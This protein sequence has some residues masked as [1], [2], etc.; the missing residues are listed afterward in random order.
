MN[1]IL[2]L[3][4]NKKFVTSFSIIFFLFSLTAIGL[5]I[6]R[7]FIDENPFER[8]L[9][10]IFYFT[11]QSNL[12][13][14]IILLLFIFKKNNKKW[15]SVLCFI[16]LI[17]ITITGL[18]FHLFLASY[19]TSIGL[20][21]HLLHTVIPILYLFFYFFIFSH[22]LQ[23]KN[24]WISLIHPLIFVVS[25][26]TWIHPFFGDTLLRVMTD[27]E[28]ASYVY[29]FLDPSIYVRGTLGLILFNFGLLTPLIFIISILMILLKRKFETSIS[30]IIL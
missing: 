17:D 22:Q 14:F 16:G 7:V 15:Y 23:L 8:F 13:I 11:T 4:N 9:V 19:M 18:V 25:V 3:R 20:M 29:P 5:L 27:L 10:T 21:Q 2:N 24:F 12:V 1:N 30:K 26:Y 28:S 6:G